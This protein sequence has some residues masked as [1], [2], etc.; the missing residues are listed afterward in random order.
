MSEEQ[1]WAAN[2]PLLA[3]VF[4]ETKYPTASRVGPPAGAAHGAAY[5][6]DHAYTFGLQRVIDGL[7]ALIGTARDPSRK[8]GERSLI[9]QRRR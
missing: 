6:P 4:D 8:P 5:D 2:A 1:W 9:I 7:G 3:R